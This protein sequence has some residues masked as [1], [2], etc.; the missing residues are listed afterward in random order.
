[1]T[2]ETALLCS[3]IV[4]VYNGQATILGCLEALAGQQMAEAPA[5]RFEVIVV[6][7]GSTDGTRGVVEGWMARQSSGRWRLLSQPNAGPAAARNS[8]AG[9]AKGSILLFTDADCIPSPT[10]VAAM[11]A[12][13]RQRAAPAAV[14]GRYLSGQRQPAARFAQYEFEERYALMSRRVQID[15]V[16]TYAAAYQ[17]AVFLAAGGFDT[18]FPK[19]NN[20]DVDFSYRLSK[21]GERMIFAPEATVSHPHTPTWRRYFATKRERAYW[22]MQVYRR[23]PDKAVADSYTPQNLKV[24]LLLG[25]PALAGLPVALVSGGWYWLLPLLLFAGAALPTV[26]FMARRDPAFGLWAFW[27]VWLRSLAFAI[28]VAWGLLHPYRG[29]AGANPRGAP[30]ASASYE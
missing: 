27:G 2:Q 12:P 4:P 17:R 20:E 13:F 26:S 7:D 10:W 25:A 16:A 23:Y 1:M 3:V 5:D 24:Q 29:L 18:S 28:G 22:R 15:L 30:A 6:D 11:T 19:A 8:G 9:A 21:A 14:M